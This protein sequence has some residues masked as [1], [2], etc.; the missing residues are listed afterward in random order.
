MNRT[1]H[2]A[3]W[4]L[5]ALFYGFYSYFV[6][7]R[8]AFLLVDYIGFLGIHIATFYFS[9]WVAFPWANPRWA[10]PTW[11]TGP[12]LALVVVLQLITIPLVVS[13]VSIIT[14]ALE[15]GFDEAAEPQTQVLNFLDVVVFLYSGLVFALVYLKF[16]KVEAQ[17]DELAEE[18]ER[19]RVRLTVAELANL[20]QSLIP[21]FY[22]N[23]LGIVNDVVR[24]HPDNAPYTI[25]IFNQIVRFYARLGPGDLVSLD[26]EIS[27]GE[28][29]TEIMEAR[30][31][32]Q[33]SVNMEVDEEARR[34]LVIPMLTTL[35]FENLSKY[36]LWD[37]AR[38]AIRIYIGLRLGH[39]IVMLRNALR[40]VSEAPPLSTK[41]GL[42]SIRERLDARNLPYMM[43]SEVRDEEF[44]FV[45]FIDF[46]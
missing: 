34:L 35:L 25:N 6:A 27:I 4:L 26:D 38:Q 12:R 5:W 37:D 45:L 19:L 30:L 39:L 28:L 21:H 24:E 9:V 14:R 29:F 43:R 22:G 11:R 17:R 31:G 44:V 13:L 40:D 32:K 33:L 18:V 1:K 41:K 20:E 8:T 2:L 46:E 3:A 36:A 15:I 7:A 23:L 16:V 42:R 10:R